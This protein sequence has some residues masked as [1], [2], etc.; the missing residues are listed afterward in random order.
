MLATR[1]GGTSSA[2]PGRDRRAVPGLPRQVCAGGT[3]Q[4][5]PEGT[6]HHLAR[7]RWTRAPGCCNWHQPIRGEE[8]RAGRP[9]E[10][11]NRCPVLA[12]VQAVGQIPPVRK[13]KD[14]WIVPVRRNLGA[15]M[16]HRSPV[17]LRRQRPRRTARSPVNNARDQNRPRAEPCP[18]ILGPAAQSRCPGSLPSRDRAE[19]A[20][21]WA[22]F[23]TPGGKAPGH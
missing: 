14:P 8:H 16:T 4:C 18:R 6:G 19:V 11:Q 15:A 3:S 13:A 7:T 21:P 23:I 12:A 17:R 20:L 1:K 10:K 22:A 2:R 5:E 9:V